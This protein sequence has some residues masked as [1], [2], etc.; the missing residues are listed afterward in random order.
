MSADDA[1]AVGG[2]ERCPRCGYTLRGLPSVGVC[3]ECGL[4]YDP[5][6]EVIRLRPLMRDYR[7]VVLAAVILLVVFLA[8]KASGEPGF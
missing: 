5:D 1:N 2:L 6:C 4:A 3:P 7:Q 8:W